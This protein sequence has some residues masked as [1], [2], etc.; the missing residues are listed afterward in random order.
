MC[1]LNSSRELAFDC[2][3]QKLKFFLIIDMCHVQSCDNF[4]TIVDLNLLV[5]TEFMEEFIFGDLF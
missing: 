4:L 3:L 2:I 5:L 1:Y